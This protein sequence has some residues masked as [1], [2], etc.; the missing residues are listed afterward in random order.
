MTKVITIYNQKGGVGKTTLAVNLAHGLVR[1]GKSVTLVDLANPPYCH[2]WFGL[3]ADG[4]ALRWLQGEAI[5]P[6]ETHA[7]ISVLPGYRPSASELLD[8]KGLFLKADEVR[9]ERFEALG[10]DAVVVD[11][12]REE[13]E[14]EES[15]LRTSDVVLIPTP[16]ETLGL[17]GTE[18]TLA[19]C[20]NLR[21]EGWRGTYY[22]V[23]WVKRAGD[24]DAFLKAGGFAD[25]VLLLCWHRGLDHGRPVFEPPRVVQLV[26]EYH[27]LV[28]WV[29]EA[30]W[31]L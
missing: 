14:I 22:V 15:L 28:M 10:T 30:L 8:G 7:G 3:S 13:W 12:Y 21:R 17:D 31:R 18:E 20:A 23:G 16:W 26:A 2:K 24:A 9:R 27:N 19:A 5:T 4:A 6:Q 1:L 29:Q 25:G 11:G